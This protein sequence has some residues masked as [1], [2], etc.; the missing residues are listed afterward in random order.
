MDTAQLH[1]ASTVKE[2]PDVWQNHF[3]LGNLFKFVY[4]KG[5]ATDFLIGFYQLSIHFALANRKNSPRP[6]LLVTRFYRNGLT[7]VCRLGYSEEK[8]NLRST[9]V[10]AGPPPVTPRE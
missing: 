10:V 5:Y 3:S 6:V 4:L 1:G 9:A 2:Q 8:Q 7:R